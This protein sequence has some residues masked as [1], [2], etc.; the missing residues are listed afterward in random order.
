[1]K[2]W[3]RVANKPRAKLHKD[4]GETLSKQEKNGTTDGEEHEK[5]ME[6]YYEPD[7]CRMK[8]MPKYLA[9]S[10]AIL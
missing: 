2:L 9:A 5:A 1:M 10:V 7:L 6:V 4:T 8:P 3:V